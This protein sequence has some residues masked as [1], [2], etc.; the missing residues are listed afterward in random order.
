[1]GRVDEIA[2]NP[3]EPN[4]VLQRKKPPA[5]SAPLSSKLEADEAEPQFC[6]RASREQ[7]SILG[8]AAF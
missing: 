4:P 2:L 8:G 7:T 3:R 1:V 6:N 5:S